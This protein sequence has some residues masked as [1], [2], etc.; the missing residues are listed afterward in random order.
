MRGR[1]RGKKR[2]NLRYKD[3]LYSKMYLLFLGDVA[4]VMMDNKQLNSSSTACFNSL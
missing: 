2:N 1:F 4:N 3:L